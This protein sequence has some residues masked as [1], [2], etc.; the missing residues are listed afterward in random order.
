MARLLN[1]KKKRKT[2]SDT[3][4]HRSEKRKLAV[5]QNVVV[6]SNKL[7]SDVYV[8]EKGSHSGPS[9]QHSEWPDMRFHPVNSQCQQEL[10]QRLGVQYHRPNRFGSGGP[11]CVLTRPNLGTVRHILGDGNCLFRAL[12]YVV[13][14]S[15]ND[16]MAVLEL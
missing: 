4:K 2:A 13:I 8:V 1:L 12:S 16:H 14:G 11:H 10:C 6:E 5:K 7:K 9:G 15:E 3:V